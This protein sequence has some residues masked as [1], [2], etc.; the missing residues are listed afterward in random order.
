MVPPGRPPLEG[1]VQVVEK[2]SKRT[3]PAV[4]P[5]AP[6]QFGGL[7]WMQ[8]VRTSKYAQPTTAAEPTAL[9]IITGAVQSAPTVS[10]VRCVAA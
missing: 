5:V 7:T 8:K 4:T 2:G 1:T 9:T 6:K 10:S 3:K